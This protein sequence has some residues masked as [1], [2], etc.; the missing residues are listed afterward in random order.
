MIRRPPRST[1]F[2][3]TT[4]FRSVSPRVTIPLGATYCHSGPS[5]EKSQLVHVVPPSVDSPQPFPT[6]PYQISPPG[7][8]PN[9]CTKSHEMEWVLV[10]LECLI[11]CQLPA[12]GR[13]TKMP[14]PYVPTQRALSGARARASTRTPK[15]VLSGSGGRDWA[16]DGSGERRKIMLASNAEHGT[17]NAEQRGEVR[18][19]ER[20][21]TAVPRS[22]FPLSRFEVPRSDFRIPFTLS[23]RRPSAAAGFP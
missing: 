8:N 15:P 21:L 6:V 18:R 4:L 19:S 1:L 23:A 3:Y 11:C 10:S 20:P 22:A 9:A 13:S 16:L 5:C 7:P 12:P 17:R 14:C 2:P